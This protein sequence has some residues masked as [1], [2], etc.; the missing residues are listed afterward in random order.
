MAGSKDFVV[1]VGP[2]AASNG[3]QGDTPCAKTLPML[4]INPNAKA[5][6]PTSSQPP[7]PWFPGEVALV[8]GVLGTEL[9][10]REVADG[11]CAHALGAG[12]RMASLNGRG[13][14]T[15]GELPRVERFWISSTST[16][17]NPWDP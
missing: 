4:C 10:S 5:P 8:D 6:D 12:W 13:F 15:Q 7:L 17:A 14:A 1:W 9:T 11:K 16:F 2:H 3:A